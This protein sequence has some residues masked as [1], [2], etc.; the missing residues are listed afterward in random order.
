MSPGAGYAGQGGYPLAGYLKG[1]PGTA[2]PLLNAS[3]A[4]GTWWAVES[5]AQRDVN[6]LQWSLGLAATGAGTITIYNTLFPDFPTF[7]EMDPDPA[8][9][10]GRWFLTPVAFT[11][12]PAGVS[13]S[14]EVL[15]MDTRWVYS[16]I[17]I[18]V[19]GPAALNPFSLRSYL[20]RS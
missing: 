19:P 3:L 18:V 15:P 14:T 8:V 9:N 13:G 17:Q 20:R 2:V 5:V 7:A 1:G 12:N 6:A 4:Q 11:G 10:P 16:L